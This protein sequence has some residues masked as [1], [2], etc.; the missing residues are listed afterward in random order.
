MARKI[1]ILGI[2]NRLLC[3]DG[4]G[5]HVVEQ[6]QQHHP[7]HPEAEFLDGGTLSFTLAVPIADASA[8]VVVDAAQVAGR[9]GAIELFEGEA[10][11][12]YLAGGGRRSVHEVGLMDMMAIARLSGTLPARRALIGIQPQETGWGEWPTAE[13]AAAIPAA[14]DLALRLVEQWQ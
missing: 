7:A 8:L 1:L 3:D 4:V 5:V 9:P 13:V 2:G 14:C 10:M 12:R 6:L 11:D